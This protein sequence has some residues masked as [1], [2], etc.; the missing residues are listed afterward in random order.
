MRLA[1]DFHGSRDDRPPLVL[2]HGLTFDRGHWQA[3]LRELDRIDPQRRV[4]AVDLPGHGGSERAPTYDLG[5]VVD[6][7]HAAVEGAGLDAP[8]LVGHSIGGLL[9]TVYAATYPAQAVVNLDQPLLPGPFGDLVRRAE[10]VLRSPSYREVWER[11]LGGMHLENLSS[12]VRRRVRATSRP[13]A[14]L[15][16]GYW[17]EL[18]VDSDEAIRE[19]RTGELATLRRRGVGYRYVT[20]TEP[21]PPYRHWLESALPDTRVTL[22]PNG[23]HFP[24]LAY[25]AEV[26]R[27]LA[28]HP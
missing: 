2:L 23:G 4:M 8:V 16:L 26:A 15:L 6:A 27:I 3:V 17:N 13:R 21:P 19:R 12:E 25:P 9:A 14:D 22:M 11:L 18:L 28:D 1:Y 24:H 20:A 5:A 10:P 7:V